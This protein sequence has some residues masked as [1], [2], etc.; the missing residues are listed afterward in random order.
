MTGPSFLIFRSS[1]DRAADGCGD[2]MA[3][4]LAFDDFVEGLFEVVDLICWFFFSRAAKPSSMR[5]R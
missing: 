3:D 1:S 2:R 5:P 4:R